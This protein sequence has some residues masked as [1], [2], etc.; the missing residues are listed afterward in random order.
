M[1]QEGIDEGL[2]KNQHK[3][4]AKVAAQT[5][6]IKDLHVK[7]DSAVAENKHMWENL[8]PKTSRPVLLMWSRKHNEQFPKQIITRGTLSV[9]VNPMH[10]FHNLQNALQGK[11]EQ[12]IP[13]NHASTVK[14]LGMNYQTVFGYK[15]RKI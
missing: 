6:Q 2:S 14:I 1:G 11:T 4:N 12:L 8:D 5:A 3:K 7:L 9:K 13:N 15:R 10:A